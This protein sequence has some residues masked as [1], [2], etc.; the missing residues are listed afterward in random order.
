MQRRERQCW[1]A[2]GGGGVG[3]RSEEEADVARAEVAP[4]ARPAIAKSKR[5]VRLG[6]L[7][8]SCVCAPYVPEAEGSSS[9]GRAFSCARG[10]RVP[11]LVR[12]LR[13]EEERRERQRGSSGSSE[14]HASAASTPS[15]PP[16]PRIRRSRTAASTAAEQ[17]VH[18][19]S[20]LRFARGFFTPR[21][22]RRRRSSFT[23]AAGARVA[24]GADAAAAIDHGASAADGAR[25]GTLVGLDGERERGQREEDG[26]RLV[27]L[28]NPRRSDVLRRCPRGR[29]SGRPAGRDARGC[30]A[31]HRSAPRGSDGA[32]PGGP[33][34]RPRRR[35]PPAP[36]PPPPRPSL[37]RAAPN[38]TR[39]R[40]ERLVVREL[41][42][43][44]RRAAPTGVARSRVE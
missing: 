36:P 27:A 12:G 31:A 4:P 28:L 21:P 17:A 14:S 40:D 37:P 3:G 24:Q 43:H 5:A 6:G 25:G 15:L 22:S 16:P 2:G 44:R 33:R 19:G 10:E 8:A 30:R 38:C 23:A 20:F 11:S 35:A 18:G 9:G 41:A 34:P 26:H 13:A 7:Q 39:V 32:E 42:K 1:E 29:R